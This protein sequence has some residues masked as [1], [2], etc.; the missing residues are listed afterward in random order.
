MKS[1]GRTLARFV[2]TPM[3]A[4]ASVGPL[5]AVSVTVGVG[6]D[7]LGRPNA[8]THPGGRL[9]TAGFTDAGPVS[10]T[11]DGS[12]IVS[13][14]T[15]HPS[16][17]PWVTR[18][19]PHPDIEGDPGID[20]VH[21][22]DALGRP[23]ARRLG[24]VAS[25]AYRMF[26]VT[27]DARGF[28]DRYARNDALFPTSTTVDADYDAQGRL[29]RYAVGAQVVR[30]RYDA[31]GNLLG[32]GGATV[33]TAAQPAVL[34]ALADAVYDEVTNHRAGW[35]YDG[36]GRQITDDRY[37]YVYNDAGRIALVRDPAGRVIDSYLYGD[38][39]DRA[40]SFD[41]DHV[42]YAIRDA[43]GAVVSEL[44]EDHI[45]GDVSHRDHVFHGTE[46]VASVAN[47][48]GPEPS[49]TFR[50]L[51]YLGSPAVEWGASPD[52]QE[53]FP[54]GHRG[55]EDGAGEGTHGFT[56]HE[57]DRTNLIYMRARYYDPRAARFLSP[58]PARDVTMRLASSHNLY[59]YTR[60][61][62]NNFVDPTGT[63]NSGRFDEVNVELR[64]KGMISKEEHHARRAANA[65]G[66][67]LALPGPEDVVI[68]L[69]I[70]KLASRGAGAALKS[71]GETLGRWAHRLLKGGDEAA[72]AVSDASKAK[73]TL[74]DQ[75]SDLVEKNGGKHRVTLRSPSGRV[76]VDLKGN[77]HGGI[78]TPHTKVSPRNWRA[79]ASK[80]PAYNS[81][82]KKAPV[83]PATQQ[84]LR[85][86]RKYLER[87]K[88]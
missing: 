39:D 75:A 4:L 69:V 10:S 44:V 82:E 15:Y 63:E 26:G 56:G 81:S 84:D 33:A 51:D 3:I 36:A 61:S 28:I 43:S 27:Y 11:Y 16:G 29:V 76:D 21:T 55:F 35:L 31:S 73:P 85:M 41:D 19:A 71:A 70:A 67:S 5:V 88:E 7:E 78:P 34:P 45:S 62:P 53:Y 57:R 38:G 79:P 64:M 58:D 8:I 46:T 12:A 47:A 20:A 60:N 17:V 2:L 66:A 68:G 59:Q 86:V 77:D 54:F 32:H 25:P 13:D 9:Q 48:S 72:E 22:A 18:Y 6:Y 52:R 50:F 42:T 23:T 40:R 83:R 49:L 87:K 74:T 14:T 65:A 30:Y 80:Q 37:R 24:D 1:L